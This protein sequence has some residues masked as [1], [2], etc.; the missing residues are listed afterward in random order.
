MSKLQALLHRWPVHGLLR[1][2]CWLGLAA[3]GLFAFPIVEPRPLPVILAMSLGQ[4]MGAVAFICYLLAVLTDAARTPPAEMPA[5]TP[6]D[7]SPGSG[8]A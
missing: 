5:A 2:A 8:D 7:A 4:L 3:L 1:F 6:S